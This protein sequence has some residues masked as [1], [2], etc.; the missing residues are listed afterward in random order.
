MK[1]TITL[2]TTDHKDA[3][4]RSFCATNHITIQPTGKV[5]RTPGGG[6]DVVYGSTSSDM[7][8]LLLDAYFGGLCNCGETY[9]GACNCVTVVK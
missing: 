8:F 3:D 6:E 5:N 4:F 7:L 2:E 9:T 1:H